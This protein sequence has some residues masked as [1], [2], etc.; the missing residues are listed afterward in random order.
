M[1]PIRYAEAC[2][3]QNNKSFLHV[4][5]S[6]GVYMKFK[7]AHNNLNVIDIDKSA[8]FYNKALGLV[9]EERIEGDGYIIMF[10]GDGMSAHKLEL[11]YLKDKEGAY[12]LGDNEIHLA[13]TV[14]DIAAS[15]ALHKEMDC[16]CYVNKDMGIY[17]IVDPDGYWLEILPAD[18]KDREYI[19]N[20]AD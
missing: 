6:E 11:T 8:A 16:V 20:L 15:Y 1:S 3:R 17:F 4:R 18:V 14:D 2:A 9:S 19:K 12:D 10:M 5:L 7:F 13:F